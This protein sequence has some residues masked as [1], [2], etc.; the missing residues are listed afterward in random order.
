MVVLGGDLV[1]HFP[2]RE[3]CRVALCAE[4]AHHFHLTECALK[5]VV[6]ESTPPQ[7]RQLIIYYY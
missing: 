1:I 2:A 6:Q 7:I 3:E 4:S 5:T